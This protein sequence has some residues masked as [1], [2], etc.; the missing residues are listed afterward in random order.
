ME[1][2]NWQAVSGSEAVLSHEGVF[3]TAAFTTPNHDPSAKHR[4]PQTRWHDWKLER[5]AFVLEIRRNATQAGE[6][7]TNKT[8][9]T[10]FWRDPPLTPPPHQLASG[11]VAFRAAAH[12]IFLSSEC[13]AQGVFGAGR[14]KPLEAV[15][16]VS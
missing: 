8:T 1:S 4:E 10:M 11:K 13:A 16:N 6:G 3:N 7:V 2:Q 12:E 15:R 9:T 5:F 14:L